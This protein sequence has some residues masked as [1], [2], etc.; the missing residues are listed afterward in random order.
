MNLAHV[1]AK[2]TV[3]THDLGYPYV[4]RAGAH[5]LADDPIVVT[6]PDLFTQDCR[7]GLTYSGEAPECLTVP[8]EYDIS[9]GPM[10]AGTRAKSRAERARAGNG[11]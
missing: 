1:F 8:P 11:G 9:S 3:S 6:R 7:Y 2:E 4:V 5:Y 10:T